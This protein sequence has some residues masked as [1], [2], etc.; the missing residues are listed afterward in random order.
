MRTVAIPRTFTWSTRAVQKFLVT[1][2]E[3]RVER[4]TLG[5]RNWFRRVSRLKSRRVLERYTWV[6]N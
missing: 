5:E 6:E 3:E 2:G 4:D 1:I